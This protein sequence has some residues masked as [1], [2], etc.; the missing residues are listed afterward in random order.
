[1]PHRKLVQIGSQAAPPAPESLPT[2]AEY[3]RE[4]SQRQ[5][6]DI[7]LLKERAQAFADLR[8]SRKAEAARRKSIREESWRLHPVIVKEPPA[9][10]KRAPAKK[11]SKS[12]S[13]A[14]KKTA[15]RLPRP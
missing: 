8:A 3:F 1:M 11:R 2:V 5:G 7:R 4:L 14:P 10:K 9:Q 15:A 12:K 6:E 13:P